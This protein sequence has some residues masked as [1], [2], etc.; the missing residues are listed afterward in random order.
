[1][2][3]AATRHHRAWL[4]IL[5]ESKRVQDV[6]RSS[7]SR[8]ATGAA[9][10]E[11]I[12]KQSVGEIYGAW[13][14]GPCYVPFIGLKM[15]E[16]PEDHPVVSMMEALPADVA[17][18]Y[19]DIDSILRPP[20]AS[21]QPCEQDSYAC[22]SVLGERREYLEYLKRPDVQQL[23][24]LI[25]AED[26][27]HTMSIAAVQKKSGD[28]LRKILMCVP[29]N[30][31]TRT[32]SEILGQEA[33][34]GL[35]GGVALGQLQSP[36]GALDVETLDQ[37]NAFSVVR[38]PCSWWRHMAGPSVR[39]CELDPRWVRGRW[40]PERKLRP[41][42]CRLAMGSTHAAFL[43]MSINFMVIRNT[44]KAN[45]KFANTALLNFASERRG[46]VVLSASQLAV[47]LHIDDLGVFGVTRAAPA[48]L[49]DL[50]A[51]AFKALGFSVTTDSVDHAGR[52][53]G[54]APRAHPA[55][56][57]P[58]AE[59]IALLD[60]SLE[61]L[62]LPGRHSVNALRTVT[63]VFIW[64]GLLWRPSL[65][66]PDRIFAFCR[67][68]AGEIRELPGRVRGEIRN[69]RGLLP[70]LFASLDKPVA[71]FVLSQDASRPRGGESSHPR[72][73]Y[74]AFAL[75]VGAPPL[76]EIHAVVRETDNVGK[77]ALVPGPM[78]SSMKR[79]GLLPDRRLMARTIIP[80]TW[81]NGSVTW[82]TVLARPWKYPAG[83]DEGELRAEVAWAKVLAA[84]D[85][86]Y[87]EEI[88][89]MSDNQGTVCLLGNG[90]SNRHH[91]NVLVRQ[92]A[93][94][95]VVGGFTI[96][97]G[98][99]PTHRQ[100]SDS[101]TRPDADG[102]LHTGLVAFDRHDYVVTVGIARE[103]CAEAA[104]VLGL[105]A[106]TL[107]LPSAVGTT[108]FLRAWIRRLMRLVECGDVRV[109]WWHWPRYGCRTELRAPEAVDLDAWL[110]EMC[111]WVSRVCASFGIAVVISAPAQH[112]CWR[113]TVIQD[114]IRLQI[115]SAAHILITPN[116]IIE[117]PVVITKDKHQHNIAATQH[118][119]IIN[120]NKST[121]TD[122]I[123]STESSYT[124]SSVR[125]R[126]NI[127]SDY[128]VGGRALTESSYTPRCGLCHG[129]RGLGGPLGVG[130]QLVKHILDLAPSPRR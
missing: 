29:F 130:A 6:R 94:H 98:W 121:I 96:R 103:V 111:A 40:P 116:A 92:F 63:A 85:V 4:T 30:N 55:R 106:L 101:G 34:Y 60:R 49:R 100:P 25:P 86:G 14:A 124:R 122:T 5:R 67:L 19:S 13:R 118:Q 50:L 21:R 104:A 87:D 10:L 108:G 7:Y 71:P 39:A 127:V 32:P 117:H 2:V 3:K 48:E 58:C 57:E 80:E 59:K 66:I 27:V 41:V 64:A 43:L 17:A 115:K 23:W 105:E 8:W 82:R 53:V 119:N 18:R 16:P 89:D 70:F 73:P 22:D 78:G 69:M 12:T 24:D 56:W 84:T 9:A 74:G 47:H 83:I 99:V 128:D 52:Y 61:R 44:L 114:I 35:L 51:K 54:Y 75:S 110:C 112:D 38:T 42:Y 28:Q 81:C 125:F 79:L 88:F 20:D 31:A 26:A 95:E 90:R 102:N 129:H 37:S 91:L 62:M 109:L 123:T 1:V 36:T 76:D 113:S 93:A 15:A 65:S 126:L 77:S 120:T 97:T 72:V 107:E 68:H 46:R 33:E 11:A 45:L